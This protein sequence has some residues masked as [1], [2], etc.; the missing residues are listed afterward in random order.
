MRLMAIWGRKFWQQFGTEGDIVAAM[1]EWSGSIDR[2]TPDELDQKLEMAKGVVEWPEVG[3]ILSIPLVPRANRL[4]HK[5]PPGDKQKGLA[6]LQAM[7]EMLGPAEPDYPK[8]V[9][10][11]EEELAK[12]QR[13]LM[14]AGCE[15]TYGRI[16]EQTLAE[17][18]RRHDE[19]VWGNKGILALGN[20]VLPAEVMTGEPA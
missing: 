10:R 5:P 9:N 13:L 12:E 8:R 6:A 11:T 17:Y 1:G 19:A 4:E 15:L 16:T 3:K 20:A 7:R 18:R 14:L 2:Y